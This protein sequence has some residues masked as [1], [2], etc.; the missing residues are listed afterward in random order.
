MH[1]ESALKPLR[2][3]VVGAG[4]AGLGLAIRLRQAGIDDYLILEKAADVGGC[5]RKTATRAPPATSL[6]SLL[7]FLRAEG[8]LVAQV[9]PAGG[10]PRL[11]AAL[12]GQVP[13]AREDPF[14][15]RGGGGPLRRRQRRMASTLRRWP[16]AARTGPGLRHRPVEP[17]AAA[18]PARPGALPGSGVP[19]GEL[20]RRGRAGRQ[21]G[22]GDRHRSQRHPV[23]PADRP[24][25]RRL[26]LFQ[27]SA[28]YVIAAGSRLRRLGTPPEGALAVAATSGSGLKYLHHESRMLAFATFPA[29][30]KVMRLSFRRHLHR[31]IAD[32]QLRARLVP[33]YPLLQA[34]PDQQRLLPGAGQEQCRTGRHGHPRSHRRR[35]GRP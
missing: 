28:P 13:S 7:V 34:H 9:R 26:S 2:V 11:P 23:R 3:L 4:F 21:A 10:N 27:R 5:W 20:G 32:P 33:D 15:L 22:R 25:V 1:N 16:D 12:R 17:A 6:A 31:Q 30:M 29:L 18:A 19:L 8:R 35:R 24:Q 14:P